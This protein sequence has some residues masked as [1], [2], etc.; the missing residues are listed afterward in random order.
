M[1]AFAGLS[2]VFVQPLSQ[3]GSFTQLGFNR[4]AGR[5]EYYVIH[6]L[7]VS[8]N[9]NFN[10]FFLKLRNRVIGYISVRNK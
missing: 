8:G 4:L 9:D 7:F 3:A 10:A 1:N 6:Q 2:K 5:I